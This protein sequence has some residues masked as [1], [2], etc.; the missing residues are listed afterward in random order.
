MKYLYHIIGGLK[1]CNSINIDYFEM[2]SSPTS[3]TTNTPTPP[4]SGMKFDWMADKDASHCVICAKQFGR[5]KNRRH[6]CRHCG[7]L[8]CGMCSSR[9]H[10]LR[11]G[12][13]SKRVCDDCFDCLSIKQQVKPDAKGGED[14][15]VQPLNA[16][17]N[18]S[19]DLVVRF[20]F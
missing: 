20:Y 12:E 1:Q 13:E 15:K 9:K 11:S 14:T 8:V 10:V 17:L 7:R 5:I 19:D 16:S 6:H 3:P 2:F 18:L 4:E